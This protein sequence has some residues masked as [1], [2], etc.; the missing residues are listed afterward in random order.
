MVCTVRITA[1]HRI[2]AFLLRKATFAF[3][4]PWG[5]AAR[6]PRN[7]RL[8]AREVQRL[9]CLHDVLGAFQTQF[10]TFQL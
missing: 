7:S 3:H 10:R 9:A 6:L 8:P 5:G 4:P 1:G 2:P